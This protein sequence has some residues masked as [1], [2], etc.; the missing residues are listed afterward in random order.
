MRSPKTCLSVGQKK[1]EI[2]GLELGTLPGLEGGE[3]TEEALKDS[4]EKPREA[5]SREPSGESP[6]E[7]W[8]ACPRLHRGENCTRRSPVTLEG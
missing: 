7:R 6:G 3:P 4:R 1:E 8:S 5:V 2:Q